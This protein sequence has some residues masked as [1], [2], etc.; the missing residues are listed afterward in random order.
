[1]HNNCN[2]VLLVTPPKWKISIGE[3]KYRMCPYRQHTTPKK[4]EGG[5]NLSSDLKSH[6]NPAP[7]PPTTASVHKPLIIHFGSDGLGGSS[8]F[9]LRSIAATTFLLVQT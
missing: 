3:L 4:E 8:F 6:A 2:A 7:V 5:A 9:M 1:M